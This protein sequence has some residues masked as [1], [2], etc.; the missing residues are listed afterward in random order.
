M[1]SVKYVNILEGNILDIVFDND[2]FIFQDDN[3]PKHRST[4]T[5][6]WKNAYHFKC[7]DWP[8]N[9]PDLNPIENI[10]FLLKSKISKLELKTKKDLINSIKNELKKIDENIIQHLIDSMPNRINEVI[11][12]KGD[13]I[14]Y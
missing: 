10:W 7:L 1:D 12:N 4:Y 14:N 6:C 3:D 2:N 8:S 5:N 9:S 11:K 13:I